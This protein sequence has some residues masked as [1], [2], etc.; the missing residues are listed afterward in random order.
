MGIG[1]KNFPRNPGIVRI[2]INATIVV[3]TANVT[4]MVTLFAPK[5][6]AFTLGPLFL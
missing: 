1:K 6:A 5:T 4:G 3:R 2:G